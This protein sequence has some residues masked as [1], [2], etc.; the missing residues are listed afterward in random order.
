MQVPNV[1]FDLQYEDNNTLVCEACGAQLESRACK[2]RCLRCGY[3]RSCSD[4][5]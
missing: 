1:S 3:F 5:F 4:L 2:L